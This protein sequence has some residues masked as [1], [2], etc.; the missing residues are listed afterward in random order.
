MVSIDGQPIEAYEGET[1]AAVLFAI[2][3]REVYAQPAPYSPN[4]VFCGMGVCMQ[5]L[6]RIDKLEGVRA[7]RTIVRQGMEIQTRP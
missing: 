4:R 2:G 1:V 7:C 5:C 3:R 6:M